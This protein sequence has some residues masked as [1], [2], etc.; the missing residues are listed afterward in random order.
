MRLRVSIALVLGMCLL[1][2]GVS[3][4]AAQAQPSPHPFEIVPGSFHLTPSTDQAGAHENLTVAFD[5][6]HEQNQHG[7][8]L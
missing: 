3:P 4:T 2:L 8:D 1:P 5:F 6:A 7:K